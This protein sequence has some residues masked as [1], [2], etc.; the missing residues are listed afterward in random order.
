M[1]DTYSKPTSGSKPPLLR[2]AG[3][4]QNIA[5]AC[6]ALTQNTLRSVLTLTG[7]VIGVVAIV[8][9]IAILQGVKAEVARQVEG[10]GANLVMIFPGKLD[11]NGQPNPMSILGKSTL[12]DR[13][14]ESIARVPGIE[15]V[16][17]VMFVSG[18]AERSVPGGKTV[19]A[20]GALVV[21]TNRQGVEM[22]PARPVLGRYYTDAEAD[23]NVCMLA[24]KMR[25]KLFGSE[26]P[27]GKTVTVQDH[28]W[29]VVGV[30]G[31]TSQ[32]SGLANQ[33]MGLGNLIYLPTKAARRQIDG[34]Q[35]N[36]I[37]LRTDYSHPADTM[38]NN[39]KEALLASHE[40]RENFG[41][42]T[43]R[44]GLAMVIKLMTMAQSLLVLVATISLF[45]AGIGIMNIM[46]VTVTER[47]REIGIRKTVGARRTDIFAQF[48]TEAMVLSILGG[49]IG[50]AISAVLCVLISTL[51][52]N[53]LQPIITAPVILMALGVSVGVGVVFGV[54][55]AIRAANLNP[56]DALRHE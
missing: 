29:R 31:K 6:R 18:T 24:D 36:R 56:I 9:L 13:D 4:S 21:A 8:T 26:D 38:I 10:L 30:L 14:I 48:L 52:H 50:V 53:E 44:R 43:L 54:T 55:P 17:P 45:V 42:V 1:I 16:S 19:A 35:I 22:N 47:T 23:Q 12:T 37:A 32:D 49:I 34:L 11:E 2:I 25:D 46:L 15:K 28:T 40:G 5:S 7:I 27:I 33:M 51:S 3:V 39:L 20:D 41:I